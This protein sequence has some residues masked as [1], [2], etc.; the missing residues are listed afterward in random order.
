MY[1]LGSEL[2]ESGTVSLVSSLTHAM[3][4]FMQ[5]LRTQRH[6]TLPA[7]QS[8]ALRL[9]PSNFSIIV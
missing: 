9:L 3:Q 6:A 1:D 7:R 8:T 2:Y 5:A 4:G